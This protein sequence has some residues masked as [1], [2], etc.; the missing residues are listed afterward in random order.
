MQGWGSLGGYS[1]Q[2]MQVGQMQD[3]S[4]TGGMAR[5]QQMGWTSPASRGMMPNYAALDPQKLI[6]MQQGMGQAMRPTG[7]YPNF[8]TMLQEMLR[9]SG[10]G[11]GM[12]QPPVPTMSSGLPTNPSF[13]QP[14]PMRPAPTPAPAPPPVAGRPPPPVARA[15]ERPVR[16]QPQ[17][18]P[19]PQQPQLSLAQRQLAMRRQLAGGPSRN[20]TM[21]DML[22]NQQLRAAL[23]RG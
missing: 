4:M 1:A 15:P 23:G 20:D 16:P 14:M 19:A 6:A 10:P 11:W 5:N 2:P 12:Q 9:Q 22:L 7:G 3:M 21:K 18:Q 13:M 8:Q 17:P